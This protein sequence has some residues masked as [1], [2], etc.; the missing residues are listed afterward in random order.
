MTQPTTRGRKA[1]RSPGVVFAA[2]AAVLIVLVAAAFTPSQPPPPPTAEFAPE[3]AKPIKAPPPNQTS[4][5]GNQGN[6]G[7][8]GGSNGLREV[9]TTPPTGAATSPPGPP[10][11]NVK[12]CVGDPARQTEDPESPPCRSFF[13]G[14]NGGATATGVDKDSIKIVMSDNE[15]ADI[16]KALVTY[17]NNRF[18]FYG[19]KLVVVSSGGCGEGS[20]AHLAQEADTI[21]QQK[22]FAA[23]GC[24]DSKGA[25]YPFYDELARKGV[26][27]VAN[28]PDLEPEAHMDQFHPYEWTFWPT[29]DRAQQLLGSLI[30]TLRG[31][32]ADHAGPPFQ[33]ATRK[34]GLIYNTF[35]DQ[36][37]PDLSAIKA[38]LA[39]CG[40]NYESGHIVLEHSSAEQGYSQDTEQQTAS[41]L[42]QFKRDNVT[43]L[44]DLVHAVT[45]QQIT[46]VASSINYEPEHVISSYLYNDSELGM[47]SLPSDQTSHLIGESA[48]N[49][50]I[51][52]QTEYWY[53]AVQEGNPNFRWTDP[54]SYKV[55]ATLYYAA[56]YSYYSLLVL[57]AGIQMAG[58][59]LTP[60]SFA[61][62]LQNT[63]FPN[64]TV[65]QHPEGKVTI[66]PGQHSYISDVSLL[67]FEPGKPES[68]YG[69]ASSFCYADFGTR[70]GTTDM[71]TKD[72]FYDDTN[73]RRWGT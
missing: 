16:T 31:K 68:S 65:P 47:E 52:P 22:V 18:E 30:C 53:Q 10:P 57:S 24:V 26:L 17:F 38:T 67:W 9:R 25:E 32:P 54:T 3:A 1:A 6:T 36:P 51:L 35:T 66:H 62:G 2:V 46:Q 72:L 71:P 45:L 48:Y 29:Y 13:T 73:C 20:P 56:W 55:D 21:A 60:Q 64:P 49:P 43:T 8:H 40:V 50:H 41:V 63:T 59:H 23:I 15:N 27:S 7:R 14:N 44:I 19:R 33:Q 37:D 61:S 11:P 34:F 28:R 42:Q 58:P 70:F 39:G 12:D 4:A 5:V 69:D